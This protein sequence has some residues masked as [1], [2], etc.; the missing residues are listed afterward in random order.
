MSIYTEKGHLIIRLSHTSSITAIRPR[1]GSE[2]TNSTKSPGIISPGPVYDHTSSDGTSFVTARSQTHSSPYRSSVNSSYRFL[3]RM[4][5]QEDEDEI[6]YSLL[7]SSGNELI[8]TTVEASSSA[9]PKE[10]IL[11]SSTDA[12]SIKT[13]RP[14]QQNKGKL[15]MNQPHEET[16]PPSPPATATSSLPTNAQKKKRMRRSVRLGSKK[17]SLLWRKPG[18]AIV[19]SR[20]PTIVTPE[21]EPIP[22]GK[23]IKIEP[24]LCMRSVKEYTGSEPSRYKA[25]KE[26]RYDLLT[27]KWRQVELVLTNSYISTYSS[28]VSI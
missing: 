12:E 4:A 19:A 13:I 14:T 21:P 7:V 11:S 22:T 8:D 9:Q 1:K 18:S 10:D 20:I 25:A 23:P 17:K 26:A 6:D 15:P 27:E 28:S 2:I 5:E 24:I 3:E 16:P